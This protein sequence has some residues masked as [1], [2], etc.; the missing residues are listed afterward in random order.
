MQTL[1]L[2]VSSDGRVFINLCE[3]YVTVIGWLLSWRG[4]GGGVGGGGVCVVSCATNFYQRCV[5]SPYSLCSF[6][7]AK[8]GRRRIARARRGV[9]KACFACD[10]APH[11]VPSDARHDWWYGP[12]GREKSGITLDSVDRDAWLFVVDGISCLVTSVSVCTEKE[13]KRDK[14]E[15]RNKKQERF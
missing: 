4:G 8:H 9:C 11:A 13:K 5:H 12:D 6:N 1:L 15:R 14:R 7:P 2:G 10:D 3:T